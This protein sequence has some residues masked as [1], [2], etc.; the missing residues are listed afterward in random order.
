MKYINVCI[1]LLYAIL[2]SRCGIEEE[3]FKDASCSV[4]N[5]ENS[6]MS[7]CQDYGKI[8]PAKTAALSQAC[9]ENEGTFQEAKA[10]SVASGSIGCAKTLSYS[11]ISVK[12]TTWFDGITNSELLDSSLTS[13]CESIETF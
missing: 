12:T 3:L 2:L 6:Q 13:S 5:Y 8:D 1:L 7:V 4:E 10:C 11:G 9:G